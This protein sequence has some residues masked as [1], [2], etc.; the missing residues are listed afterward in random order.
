MTPYTTLCSRLTS[1]S[2][3]M[4]TSSL[5]EKKQL[6]KLRCMRATLHI[7]PHDL[8]GI[9]HMATLR[10]RL[11]SC[12]S[13]FTKNNIPREV[14][15]QFQGIL[16]DYV[17]IPQKAI[18]LETL[19]I[20]QLS[21][22]DNQKQLCAKK[23]LKYFWEMGTLCYVNVAKDWEKEERRYA[24]TKK[25]YPGLYLSELSIDEAQDQ[26]AYYYLKRFGPATVKDFAWWSGLSAKVMLDYIKKTGDLVVSIQFNGLKS[27]FYMLA[28]EY[29]MLH[30]YHCMNT[31]WVSLLAYE[32]PSLKGYYESRVR[33][34]DE[35][36]YNLFFNQ[37]GEVRAGVMH[38]GKA[39]GI[40]GWDK[41]KKHVII[42]YFSLV[43]EE[44]KRKVNKVKEAY[45][46]MLFPRRQLTFFDES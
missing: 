45:E 24:L 38:N 26:L 12:F 30:S 43:A 13:Y 19:I 23:V 20:N 28:E 3:E 15:E 46:S 17:C 37:I 9:V 8:A 14:I 39:I 11:V 44:I 32:D 31:G 21:I 25:Y 5:Y 33:Y 41:K 29:D 16:N 40:W 2:P 6:I 22:D 42:E 18:D 10:L 4:L 36:F 7:V 1:Y 27:E 35:R 34:V